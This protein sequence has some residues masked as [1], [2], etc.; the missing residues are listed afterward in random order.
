M[1]RILI[2]LA[3]TMGLVV[4]AGLKAED[5]PDFF[6]FWPDTLVVTRSVY[7]GTADTITIGQALPLGCVGG[8]T[9]TTVNVP[10]IAGG[11]T[12]VTVPCGVASDNGEFPNLRD[13]HNVWNNA[14]TDGSFGISSPIFLDNITEF[15][16]R[17]GTLAVP[18]NKIVTSFTSKS[19]L[20]INLSTDGKSLTFMGYQGGQGCGTGGELLSPTAPNLIDVS[21]SNTPGICDPT[22]PVI[23]SDPSNPT[24]PTAY[25]RAVAEVDTQGHITI[26]PGNAYSGDNGRAAMKGGNG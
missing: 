13:S 9:G 10:L 7:T 25:Y 23:S 5:D 17:L 6:R 8:A 14:N 3:G 4:V 21:A 15:G 26:T 16:L 20:A 11:T 24:K 19:E 22:N 1:R 18:A 12:P 2:G